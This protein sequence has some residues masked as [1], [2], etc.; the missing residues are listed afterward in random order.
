MIRTAPASV[1]KP[2]SKSL[3]DGEDHQVV[4]HLERGGDDPGGDDPA[5][6]LGRGVDR[7][8]HAEEASGPAS[9]SR[10]RL[11][12]TLLTIPKVPSWPTIRPVR[13]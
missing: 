3:L 1:G 4:E 2:K 5:H 13:S 9:G 7:V 8:K 6:R 12:T 10:A 11:T